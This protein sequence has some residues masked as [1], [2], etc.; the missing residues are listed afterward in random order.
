MNGI[1]LLICRFIYDINYLEKINEVGYLLNKIVS[2]FLSVCLVLTSLISGLFAVE[3][4]L[5]IVVPENWELCVGDSRTLECVYSEKITDRNVTWSVKPENI[6]S[7]DKWGRVTAK[8]IGQATITAQGNGF[9]DSVFLNVVKSPTM[10]DNH[11]KTKKDYK[12][13][14]VKEVDNLQKL[15]ARHPHG[16]AEIPEFISSV[17]DYSN[18]QKA[19]TAD[20]AIWEIT[21]YGVLRTDK[22]AATERD[23]EQRFMGNRYFYSDDTSSGNVLA[24]FP[25]GEYGIWTVMQSGVTH[26]QMINA[27]GKLK[28]TYLSGIT[29]D[30]IN[31]HGLINEAYISDGIWKG[32]E[33]DND[34]LWTSMYGAGELMRYA[35]LR[36]DPNA[37]SDEIATA[38]AAAYSAS[39]AVLLLYYISMRSGTTE[40]YVRRQTTQTIPGTTADRWLSAESLESGGDP[41]VMIPAKSPAKLF[42]EAMAT[43]TL[44]G[45]ASRLEN[46]GF[47]KAV[48]PDD[49]SDPAENYTTQ[50]EKQIRLLEGFPAR[51]FRLKTE[52]F[53]F[54]DNIYWSVNNNGT[55]TGISEKKEGQNGYLLNNEN[56]RGVTVDASAKVPERLWNNLIGEEYSP[57]DIIYKTDTSAD[58]LIGHMFIFK[59]IYDII[60]PED[61]EIREL[62]VNAIDNLAQHLSDNSY[63]LVD[64]T[65][66][67]TTW[68]NFGRTLFCTGSSVAE[69]SLHSLVL[70]TIFKTAAYITGYQKWENEYKMVALDPAY[71]YAK[72]TSQHYERMI[73]AVKYTVGNATIH[74]LGN[75]VGALRNTDIVET[76]YRLIVNYSSEEMA[77][78]GFYTIFQLENDEAILKYYREAIDDW[79]ISIKY[80][81]NPLWYFVYQLAYPDKTINDAYNNNIINTAT[82]SLS[83]HPA[84][85][86]MYHASNSSRDDIAELNTADV[87]INLRERLTYNLKTSP[88]LPEPADNP[89]II[90]IT[91]FVL[92]ASK[93]NWAVAAPDERSIH[94]YN[95][96]SYFLDWYHNTNCMQASTT[97]TLPYWMG[98]YHQIIEY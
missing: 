13:N 47:Y 85:L 18:Y 1:F 25:D 9:S 34:G 77:M 29:Q 49:W 72:I 8:E 65:G 97:Y 15:V 80:S 58:E 82:W 6:A 54:H 84:D 94:K 3:E 21:D 4:K 5:R 10:M 14:S 19:I 74:L 42:D 90:D 91:K 64:A 43:Y 96:S 41:S 83:R 69:T 88:E 61:P 24:I 33:S 38:K 22:N 79:W 59:L 62:L 89:E 95:E 66:Q 87:G 11:I 63:M 2:F 81:E 7:V 70:L 75:I 71:E 55:A 26:I 12:L 35:A 17:K 50:Y 78:L 40:A 93:L 92:I 27:D 51:T 52:H 20:G 28:A 53:D 45:S 32:Y 30:N 48:S 67:P 57:E 39:E 68:A 16:S 98:I 31:R 23:I 56:L 86:V 44:F 76:I 37:T 36:D 46:N 60:A 73:A